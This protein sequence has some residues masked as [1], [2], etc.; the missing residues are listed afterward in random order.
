MPY[1]V[2]FT[3]SE[4]KSP[5]TV[6]DNTSSQDTSLT[7]PGRN[8]TGYGQIIAE[9][10]LKLLE[11]FASSSQPVNP[12]EGQLWYDTTNGVLQ[13]Y[14]NTNWKAASNIQ[15]SPTEP[16][17]ENSKVGELWVDTTNQ[18]LRIYTGT[19]W[20]LVGPS[21][22]AIDGLRY[23]PAIEKIVD[24]DNLDKNVL[25]LYIADIP[26]A[27]VSKDTFTPKIQIA[28]FDRVYS[29]INIA[30]PANPD[31]Q[32]SFES[33][34][35]GGFLPKLIGTAK[36]ADALNVSGNEIEAGKFLRSDTTNTTEF[37][38]N[39]RTNQGL[40][41]GIDN[42]FQL[43]TSATSAKIYNSAAGSSLDL[44]VNR[45]GVP[46]T[47]LRVLDNKV[48]INVAS[49]DNA[50]DVDGDV[51]LT[52]SLIVDNT[53]DSINLNTGSIRTAG[54]VAIS[55]NLR[56]GTTLNVSGLSTLTNVIPNETNTYDLGNSASRWK[57]ITAKTIVADEIQGTIN[58][59]ITGNA[60]TATNLKNVTSFS[61][62][63]DVI[64]PALQF[65]G[66]VG[67]YTKIFN[68]QLTANIIKSKSQPIPNV[69][70]REDQVLVYRASLETGGSSGLLKQNRDTFV[71]D[72]GVPI[73]TVMPYA[74]VNA[75]YGYLLCDGGEVEI[76]KFQ[77]LYDIIGTRYNGSAALNGTGTFRIPDLRGRFPLGKH[78]MDNNIQV[79][80]SIGG[81]VDNGGG[82]PSPARVAGTE[83]ETLAASSGSSSVTLN[84]TNLPEHSH[85]LVADGQQFFGVRVDTAPTV[86]STPGRGPNNP[87][88][89]QYIPDTGGVKIPSGASLSEPVGIM[90][91]F[92]TLNYIIRSGPP[93]FTT[94]GTP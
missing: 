31:E 30:T 37:S 34:F 32:S 92:Q 67:S 66:Q 75:P 72:L 84:L 53:N 68:T 46:S 1:I 69:S 33:I 6:F 77:Q 11:N 71:G 4:N 26:V 28:G 82:T 80:N 91:P 49:P 62:T 38:F 44:Q 55:K 87:G 17:V 23:G 73:G 20:L 13:L 39:I 51:G 18:Q 64:A 40:V 79:P 83:A 27:I 25:I 5:I 61:M 52:G 47:I 90:N 22:S 48:G 74:G 41:I 29:G 60:N 59:N 8:V 43:T 7:F 85:D 14:D 81:F 57:T 58:G 2:N 35:L 24:Q 16:S 70:T 88:E 19:R 12:I 36:N 89:A 93:A 9:N 94:I 10:F 65:D 56:V 86:S 78:N 45:N 50:L 63:G 21:E 76:K 3:D 42:N 54:G 15:K